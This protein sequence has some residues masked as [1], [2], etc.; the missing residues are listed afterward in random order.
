MG[1]YRVVCVEPH[2]QVPETGEEFRFH[3]P[4][5]EQRRNDMEPLNAAAAGSPSDG[6]VHA[7]VD[8]RHHPAIPLTDMVSIHLKVRTSKARLAAG[9]IISHHFPGG[10]VTHAQLF[11][12]ALCRNFT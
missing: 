1:T 10:I 12:L 11:E 7:L 9:L 2:S 3:I 8:G 4:G 6:I 5:M